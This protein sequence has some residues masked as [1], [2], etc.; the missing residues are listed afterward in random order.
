VHFRV[1]AL[2]SAEP[3]APSSPSTWPRHWPPWR[4]WPWRGNQEKP[5]SSL[6]LLL[7]LQ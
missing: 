3:G 1:H 7:Y 5:G 2:V 6:F 4:G